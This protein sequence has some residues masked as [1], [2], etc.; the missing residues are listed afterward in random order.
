MTN[1]SNETSTVLDDIAG[2]Y[3]IDASHTHIGFSTR[4]AM[5]TTVRGSFKEFEGTATIDTATPASST[6]Q[7]SIT[8]SSID[9]GNADRDGHLLSG[10]FFES[11]ANPLITFSSTAVAFDGETWEITGDLT[12]KGVTNSVTVPF[13]QTG[14]AQ[15]RGAR[16]AWASRVRPRSSAPTG[17]CPGTPRSRPAACSSRTRSS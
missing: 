15:D 14:S 8:A 9:T 17:A 4:H 6:V 1:T 7:L 5:V 10:D 12:I 3:V 16:P 13:E 2:T 11:E